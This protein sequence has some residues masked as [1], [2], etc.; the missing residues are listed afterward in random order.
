MVKI[1]TGKLIAKCDW[2]SPI[3]SFCVICHTSMTMHIPGKPFNFSLLPQFIELI[4]NI[5]SLRY[6]V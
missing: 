5:H 3:K 6:D 2:K 1:R 4:R